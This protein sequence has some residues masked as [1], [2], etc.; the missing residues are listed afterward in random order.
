MTVVTGLHQTSG[1]DV[2]RFRIGAWTQIVNLDQTDASYVI[3]AANDGGVI[4][5]NG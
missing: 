3:L 4:L 2:R 1:G 5:R